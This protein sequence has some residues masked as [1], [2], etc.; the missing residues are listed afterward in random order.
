MAKYK[1]GDW[2]RLKG[3]RNDVIVFHIIQV[4][5]VACDVGTQIWYEARRWEFGSCSAGLIVIN[6]IEV[7]EKVKEPERIKRN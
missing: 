3:T 2:I 6:E 7:A 5:S 1:P 4:R